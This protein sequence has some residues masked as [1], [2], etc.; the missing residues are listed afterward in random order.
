MTNA[1]IIELYKAENGIKCPLH[2]YAKWKSLGYQVKKGEKSE[3]RITIWKGCT[4][5]THDE[6]SNVEI[7]SSKVIMK[8]ACFF[9]MNQVEKIENPLM[10]R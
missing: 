4:K 9:T 2:T 5:K 3:H 8:T 7:V 10:S 6:E 1:M